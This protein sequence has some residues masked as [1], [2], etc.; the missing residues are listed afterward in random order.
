MSD[1]LRLNDDKPLMIDE[2]LSHDLLLILS[3]KKAHIRY[4][5]NAKGPWHIF[6]FREKTN[7][8]L[9][10][11]GLISTDSEVHMAYL[12]L[13]NESFI[14]D[15][16]FAVL[17]GASLDIKSIYLGDNIKNIIFDISNKEAD[18]KVNIDNSIVALKDSDFNIKVI[19]NIVKGAKGAIHHQ[20]SRCLT[21]GPLKRSLISP[22]LNIDENDVE[23]SHAMTSGTVDEEML[24]YMNA[25]GLDRNKALSLMVE[26]YLTYSDELYKDFGIA[27][28][29]QKE[30]KDR[31]ANLC[32]M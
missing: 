9:I 31:E 13:A 27:E 21:L 20:K 32:L 6:I 22:I 1:L 24:Y 12:D 7:I 18:T 3:G 2:S 25:R 4:N 28:N 19:G 11:E 17:K 26:S 16:K 15:S 14:Q 10:E 23:A 29:W 8:S 30:F 5:L